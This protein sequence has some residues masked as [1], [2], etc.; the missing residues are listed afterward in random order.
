V[1]DVRR[2]CVWRVCEGCAGCDCSGVFVSPAVSLTGFE[3]RFSVASV[4]VA[5]L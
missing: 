1:T 5:V 2:L 4:A 3:G